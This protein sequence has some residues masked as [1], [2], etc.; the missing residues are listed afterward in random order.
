MTPNETAVQFECGNELLIGIHH[1]TQSDRKIGVLIIVGGPQYRT[2]SHRQFTL[3]A[4][5][6]AQQGI[7]A[8]RFDNRGMGDSTGAARDFENIAEDIRCALDAFGKASPNIQE[9][10]LWGLCDAATACAIYA[11]HD[12]RVTGLVLANPWVRNDR[13]HAQAHLKH[14]FPQR[15][16]QPAFWKKLFSGKLN[17]VQAGTSFLQQHRLARSTQSESCPALAERMLGGLQQFQGRV[18]IILSGNDLTAQEFAEA[19]R[20]NAAW[21]QLFDHPAFSSHQ[22]AQADHTFSC[23]AWRDQVAEWTVEWI[24]LN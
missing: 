5:H 12:R 15:I 2:G 21:R 20:S 18:L 24:K 4:R 14:Y 1:G 3:L 22:L 10:V 6:L 8:F 19:T 16:M 13:T 11:H 7:P 23:R 17:L 9:F